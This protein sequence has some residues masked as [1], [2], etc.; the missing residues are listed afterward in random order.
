MVIVALP[1]PGTAVG[2]P[3]APGAAIVH[4]AV[5]VLFPVTL[6]TDVDGLITVAPSLQPLKVKPFLV[7]AAAVVKPWP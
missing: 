4:C 6:V 3:G 5:K 1:S 2:I 7:G